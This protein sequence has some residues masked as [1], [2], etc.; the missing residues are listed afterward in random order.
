M[1]MPIRIGETSTLNIEMEIS[2]L[3]NEGEVISGVGNDCKAPLDALCKMSC[4]CEGDYSLN[5]L[6]DLF[7]FTVNMRNLYKELRDFGYLVLE[8]VI[9]LPH[10]IACARGLA[11]MRVAVV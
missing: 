1:I 7:I 10:L 8:S 5:N 11:I 9:A 2:H 3:D 6:E 4:R